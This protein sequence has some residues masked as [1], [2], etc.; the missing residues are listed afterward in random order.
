MAARERR[1]ASGAPRPKRRG[2]K[3]AGPPGSPSESGGSSSDEVSCNGKAQELQ[4][5]RLRLDEG[6]LQRVQKIEKQQRQQQHRVFL[7]ADGGEEQQKHKA[8]QVHQQHQL[9]SKLVAL[10]VG[11]NSVLRLANNFPAASV[12]RLLQQKEQSETAA[13]MEAL[14]KEAAGTFV[15]LRWL[16]QLVLQQSSLVTA[17][18]AAESEA[19]APTAAG[20]GWQQRRDTHKQNHIKGGETDVWDNVGDL[21]FTSGLR[22]ACLANADAWHQQT[23]TQVSIEPHP[24]TSLLSTS[25][26]F[27]A[28][29]LA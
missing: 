25:L 27:P 20:G 23:G 21:L 8:Q 14:R 7:V 16:H 15:L 5:K 2:R 9:H 17:Y 10:R 1:G 3:P 11:M 26:L 22:S 28:E 18:R 19:A 29:Q 6:L 12:L 13:A 24:G 4:V